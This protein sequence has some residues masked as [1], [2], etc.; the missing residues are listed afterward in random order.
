MTIGQSGGFGQMPGGLGE[1]Q[2]P[3]M[4]GKSLLIPGGRGGRPFGG[5][6]EGGVGFVPRPGG[7]PEPPG[8]ELSISASDGAGTM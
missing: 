7:S 6:I 5:Q 3:G 4:L 2:T 8:S 1:G